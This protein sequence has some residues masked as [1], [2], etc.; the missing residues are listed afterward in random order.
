MEIAQRRQQVV[1]DAFDLIG[2]GLMLRQAN[3]EVVSDGKLH[4]QM[5][6]MLVVVEVKQWNDVLM[7]SPCLN[8]DF[9]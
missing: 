2:G 3:G 5:Y 6:E 9:V 7:I 1:G 8:S 4:Q